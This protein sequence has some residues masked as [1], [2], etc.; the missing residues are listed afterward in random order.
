MASESCVSPVLSL[1]AK[2][3]THSDRPLPPGAA[4]R[5]FVAGWIC[6]L[7]SWLLI[8]ASFTAITY[9]IPSG[10]PM[11]PLATGYAVSTAAISLAMVIGFASLLPGG[12][13]IRELVLT[14][15]LGVSLGPAHGLIAALTARLVFLVVEAVWGSFAWLW[16]RRG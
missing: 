16:L 4:T 15:V 3:F 6:S 14:T 9:A 13:G 10:T 2:R 8:G 7:A 12:A 1:A 5:L 11:P